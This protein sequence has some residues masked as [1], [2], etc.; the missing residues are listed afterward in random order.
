MCGPCANDTH[1]PP[2][3]NKRDLQNPS[4]STRTNDAAPLLLNYRQYLN[5]QGNSPFRT[6]HTFDFF[7]GDIVLRP[8]LGT[9]TGVPF[10][11]KYSGFK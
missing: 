1:T 8:I 6:K 7:N 2:A 11:I 5:A 10:K 3:E 9:I 4:I